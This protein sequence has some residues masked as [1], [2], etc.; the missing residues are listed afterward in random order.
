[1]TLSFAY[2]LFVYTFRFAAIR[3]NQ[4][5]WGFLPGWAQPVFIVLILLGLGAVLLLW[6][7]K[8]T[9]FIILV[10]LVVVNFIFNLV[11]LGPI[12]FISLIM[13]LIGIL[14]LYFAMKPVWFDFK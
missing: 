3:D 11:T 8:M 9:G 14:I 7:W 13:A 10:L 1:M 2:S 4:S 6:N 12:A 5:G